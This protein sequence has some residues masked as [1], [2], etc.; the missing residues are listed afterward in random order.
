MRNALIGLGVFAAA[1]V[2]IKYA[3]PDTPAAEPFGGLK[4]EMSTVYIDLGEG[5][6]SG[7]FIGQRRIIT[8]A[9]CA[10]HTKAGDVTVEFTDFKPIHGKVQWFD[11][12]ADVALVLIDA[13]PED[14]QGAVFVA[15]AADLA[16]SSPDVQVG[17]ALEV[18]GNPLDLRNVHTYGWVAAGVEDRGEGEE[19]ST[20]LQRNFVGDITIAPGNSGGPAFTLN[21]KVAG[22]VVAI[23]LYPLGYTPAPARLAY[24]IPKSVICTEL[25]AQHPAPEFEQVA[26]KKHSH[27]RYGKLE[28]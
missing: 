8:A 3:T 7:V 11:A 12:D 13:L 20:K 19:P 22:I 15:P 5:S 1:A 4:S 9:H 23:P 27:R 28:N 2:G 25:A 10:R 14:P 16:C 21:G 24:I 18:I 6:C 26:G 17:D